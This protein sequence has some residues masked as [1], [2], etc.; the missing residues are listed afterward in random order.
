MRLLRPVCRAILLAS[1]A[2][3]PSACAT[4][5]GGN[6]AGVPRSA[7]ADADVIAV[8]ESLQAK[9]DAEAAAALFLQV[10]GRN[11]ENRRVLIGLA[12]SLGAMRN[13]EAALRYYGEALALDGQDFDALSGAGRCALR[14]HR[15][16]LA[17]RYLDSA[18]A[19]PAA[20]AG[21]HAALGVAY[22]LLGQHERAQAVYTQGL[23]RDPGNRTLTGNLAL[24]LALAAE[25]DE[26]AAKLR[27][28]ADAADA[29]PADRQNMAAVLALGGELGEARRYAE[30]DLPAAEALQN[31]ET[32][33]AIARDLYG[34][35]PA[36]R[37][38]ARHDL[39]G[40]ALRS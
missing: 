8:A 39:L 18:A 19:L 14:L 20:T 5:G 6:G 1:L 3:A 25:F 2:V 4:L 35:D 23:A 7:S 36:R 11:P 26:A 37:T 9:G 10:Y 15:A 24:S 32:L 29:Q 13:C 27:P 34:E 21:T 33:T 12:D 31:I 17:A 28:L 38:A 40:P 22:D 30:M 16:E